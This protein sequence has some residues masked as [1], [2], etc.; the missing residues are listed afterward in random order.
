MILRC[1]PRDLDLDERVRLMGVLNVT[2]DSFSDGGRFIDVS[3]AVGRA[4]E[5]VVEGADIIDVGGESTRPGA[6]PVDEQVEM[7]RVIPV[8]EELR[9]RS[10]VFISID[11]SKAAVA[12]AACAAG[13]DIVNDVTA[14]RGDDAMRDL[15]ADRGA[16]LV[17]MHMQGDPRTMQTTPTYDDVIVEVS[18][19]LTEAARSAEDAGIKRDSIVIDPGIG[20][21]KTVEH[22]L[23]LIRSIDRFVETGYPV[24]VGPSRKTFIGKVLD[25]DV[26]ERVEGTAAVCVWCVS[27]GVRLL[28]VHDV[29]AIHRAVRMTEALMG[30]P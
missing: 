21:G 27:R 4:L 24:L 10:D 5:M 7:G 23:S 20:F 18:A 22:N 2:P 11:T 19:F 17:L 15:V 13:A 8:I 25:V 6:E 12:D 30:P 3:Q 28:R 29:Q 1:G 9:S 14:L 26:G 16:G